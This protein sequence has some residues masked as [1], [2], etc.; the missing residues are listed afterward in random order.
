MAERVCKF[1]DP[2]CPCQDGDPCNYEDHGDTKAMPAPPRFTVHEYDD[3]SWGGKKFGI[4]DARGWWADDLGWFLSREPA[5]RAA[6]AA[7]EEVA[8]GA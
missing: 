3:R 5:E 2:T 7:N 4:W 6:E 8:E 1:G